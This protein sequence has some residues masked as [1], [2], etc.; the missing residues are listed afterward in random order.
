MVKSASGVLEDD[1]DATT[2]SIMLLSAK[3]KK[4]RVLSLTY[5]SKDDDMSRR[6]TAS[7]RRVSEWLCIFLPDDNVG[8]SIHEF[9]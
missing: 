2:K 7:Q 6:T 3:S 8:C 4:R 5:L 1:A 9:V